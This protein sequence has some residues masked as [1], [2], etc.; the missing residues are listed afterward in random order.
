MVLIIVIPGA[1]LGGI[2]ILTIE[3]KSRH[4]SKMAFPVNCVMIFQR[5][6]YSIEG[7]PYSYVWQSE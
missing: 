3:I 4:M 5:T 2:N 7:W 6:N 1:S